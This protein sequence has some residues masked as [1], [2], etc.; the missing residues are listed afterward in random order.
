MGSRVE[1]NTRI[2]K[3]RRRKIQQFINLLKLQI[4]IFIFILMAYSIF[5]VNETIVELNCLDNPNLFVLDRINNQMIFMGK[6]YNINLEVFKKL[7]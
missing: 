3:N 2:E 7:F 5:L 1:R 6:T 4:I